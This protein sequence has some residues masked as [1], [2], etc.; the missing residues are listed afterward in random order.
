MAQQSQQTSETHQQVTVETNNFHRVLEYFDDN[1]NII[2]P[3]KTRFELSCQICGDKS[4]ALVND[5]LDRRSRE[6]HECYTVL[7]LC[8][9]GFGYRCLYSWLIT[10]L[11]GDPTCPT[12]RLPVFLPGAIKS[13]MLEIFGD[14]GIQEQ[15]EEIVEIR[16]IVLEG[17]Q[18]ADSEEQRSEYSVDLDFDDVD[19]DLQPLLPAQLALLETIR[20]SINEIRVEL[21]REGAEPSAAQLLDGQPGSVNQ[22]TSNPMAEHEEMERQIYEQYLRGTHRWGNE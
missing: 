2:N 15:N 8:G 20:D 3:T 16:K 6:T 19:D 12:C 22:R 10:N 1:G 7:P 11:Y 5:H 18:K 13:S 17:K 4:L 9:H 14:G 21:R